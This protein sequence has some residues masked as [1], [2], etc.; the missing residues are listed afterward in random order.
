VAASPGL[1]L[2]SSA[3]NNAAVASPPVMPESRITV[4][5]GDELTLF[6]EG[7][8]AICDLSPR[9]EVVGQCADGAM[10]LRLIHDLSPDIAVLDI[11][12]TG[13]HTIELI[14]QVKAAGL[15]TRIAVL[16]ARTDRKTVLEALRAGASAFLLKSGPARHL[17]E[18]F[19]QMIEG[20][21]YLSPLLNLDEIFFSPEKPVPEDPIDA[22]SPR[23]F[24]VF[25]L[26]V[27][28]VRAKEIAAR[29]CLS[30]KTVDTYRSS[31]MEK[32]DIHDIAGLVKYAMQRD[33]ISRG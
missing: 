10:A 2:A 27:E 5:L 25:S 32:L 11:N 30:P 24:Q 14:R 7:L 15:P 9:C 12:L 22:L 20:A 19:E 16:S 13:L 28:G 31:M 4:V 8:A 6:R 17:I 21:I 3:V 29:L 33:L 23:E 1:A 26:L 18:S